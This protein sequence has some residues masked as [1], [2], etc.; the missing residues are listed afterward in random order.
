MFVDNNATDGSAALAREIAARSARPFVFTA[1][2]AQGASPARNHGYGLARG[3]YILWFDAD[4]WMA[5]DKIERQVAALERDPAAA[6]ADC[7]DPRRLRPG[8]APLEHR[9]QLKQDDDQITRTL[10]GI[11]YPPHAY[12]LR[13]SAADR[14]LE[15]LGHASQ[16]RVVA[17]SRLIRIEHLA[18]STGHL[19]RFVVFGSIEL[20]SP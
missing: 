15:R 13:R 1:C 12:L 19:A 9:T 11:W 7:G 17:A 14:L 3:D 4:D 6:I 8:E 20:E 10:S 16:R 18:R 2:A 5:P